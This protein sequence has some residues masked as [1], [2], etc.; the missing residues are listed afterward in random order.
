M[1]KNTFVAEV[2]FRVV[3]SSFFYLFLILVATINQIQYLV[4]KV[5]IPLKVQCYA[6]VVRRVII[7][8]PRI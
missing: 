4:R 1:A 3:E 6:L 7:A 2:T 8:P 5:I